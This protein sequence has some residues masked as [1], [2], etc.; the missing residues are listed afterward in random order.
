MTASMWSWGAA[1]PLD[2][3]CA[4]CALELGAWRKDATQWSH[5]DGN[6][7]VTLQPLVDTFGRTAQSYSTTA[8]LFP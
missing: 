2:S 3:A 5:F 7:F 8:V 1:V 6:K 4:C